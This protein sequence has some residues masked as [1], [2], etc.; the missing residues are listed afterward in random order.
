MACSPCWRCSP[1]AAPAL[2]AGGRI[3]RDHPPV[4]D[5]RARAPQPAAA[6]P[7][8]A[9]RGRAAVLDRARR[10]AASATTPTLAEDSLDWT[11][12]IISQGLFACRGAR[13]SCSGSMPVITLVVVV[14]L[15]IVVAVARRASAA[16]EPLPRG[17]QRRRPARSP[18]RSAISWR[19]CRRSR[20][21]APRSAVVAHFRR[22]NEQRRS[23]MLAD[24]RGHAG[25]RRRHRQ[26][27]EH[28][29]RADH[30]AGRRR[31]ARRQR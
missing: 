14:P 19:R 7:G 25:D 17:Q 4:H 11:D 9:G 24:R 5:E 18:G 22:L 26:H 29:H 16:L 1:S 15:V 10:S 20:P 6:C 30:A 31:P 23:A 27:G 2:V 21:P 8:P 3:R 13:A 28:R 12:E